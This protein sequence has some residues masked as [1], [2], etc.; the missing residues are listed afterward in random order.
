[1]TR[2]RGPA[3]VAVLVLLAPSLASAQ[4]EAEA[5]APASADQIT[6]I[7]PPDFWEGGG[8]RI[9]EDTVLHPNVTLVGAYQPNVFF[10]DSRDLPSGPISSPLLR[11][12]VGASWGSLTPGRM[13]L[14]A[15]TSDSARPRFSF[16][17]DGGVTWYQY[18]SSNSDVTSQ[19]DLGIQFLGDAV[20]NPQGVLSLEL[21]DGFVRNVA[22]GQQLRENADRDEN[23]L[24]A[25]VHFRPGGGALDLYLGYQFVVDVFEA[26]ILDYDDRISHYATLG[27]GWQWLPHTLL[28]LQGTAGLVNPNNTDFKSKSKPV[29]VTLTASSL[30]TPVFGAIVSGG[31]GNGFYDTGENVSTWL[32]TAELRYAI[33][34][35][36]RSAIGY[37]HG[38]ADAL[39]GN[40]YIDHTIYG[41][42]SAQ[43]G[44]RWQARAL[45]E[46]RFRSY[47]GIHDAMDLL[48]CGDASCPKTRSDTL[49][50]LEVG[51][52]Y[53]LTPW[54]ILGASYLIQNDTTDF[55][56]QGTNGDRDYGAYTWQE[57]DL[58]ITAKW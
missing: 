9:G 58:R 23:Q 20:F 24:S 5:N 53:A 14:E 25:T 19:D 2:F 8:V 11:I 22:P 34:P 35:T 55:F 30:L 37:T 17:L 1:V 57:F 46:I 15:P 52:D 56:V 40:F 16:H 12:G 43:L 3:A 54:L 42:V 18:L 21:S 27:I 32:A 28:K 7:P 4:V 45:G 41:R 13:D 49:P 10:Q 31:Y 47:G 6:D 29:T 51:T 48:F 50:R 33:G 44:A 26:S 39:I 36:L 38:F